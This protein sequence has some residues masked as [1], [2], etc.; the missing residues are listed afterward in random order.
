MPKPKPIDLPVVA[1]PPGWRRRAACLDA[2]TSLFFGGDY[3]SA[4]AVHEFCRWCEVRTECLQHALATDEPYGVW[5]GLTPRQRRR[6][7][8][9][10]ARRRRVPA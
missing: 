5:G 7:A 4:N 2:D 1:P 6:V 9:D 3:D 8:R 10:A